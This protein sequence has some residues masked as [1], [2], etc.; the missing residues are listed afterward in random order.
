MASLEL[1]VKPNSELS[2]VKRVERA[3]KDTIA[4]GRAGSLQVD[5][6]FLELSAPEVVKTS[7]DEETGLYPALIG[8][9]LWIVIGCVA[10]LILLALVQAVLTIYKSAG[11]PSSQ[12]VRNSFLLLVLY[13]FELT[14]MI[15][16]LFLPQLG[17][18]S[19]LER[20]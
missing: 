2:E 1:M 10:A 9:R 18:R 5:P 14:S 15:P 20:N 4:S 6:T 11:K 16:V 7:E 13:K 3:L 19:L 17:N 12:K 8:T